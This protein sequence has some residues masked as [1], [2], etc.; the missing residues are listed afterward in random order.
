MRQYQWLYE[1][2]WFM[3]AG[4]IAYVTTFTVSNYI[5]SM[6]YLWLFCGVFLAVT[7]FRWIAFPEKSVL[8]MSFWVKCFLMLANVPLFIWGINR[9]L[10]LVEVFDSFNGTFENLSEQ[11]V[12]NT[13][14]ISMLMYLKSITTLV[15]VSALILIILFFFRSLHLIFKWR[16]VPKNILK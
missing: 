1:I 7:Y 11:H 12:I 16:Q 2:L 14:P 10:Q 13:I 15:A 3:L 8:M 9:F 5:S 6:F 4:I